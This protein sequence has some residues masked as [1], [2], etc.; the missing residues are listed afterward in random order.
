ML[1]RYYQ[2]LSEVIKWF[3]VENATSLGFSLNEIMF[4]RKVNKKR[5]NCFL[6]ES[7]TS[8]YCLQ[9]NVFTTQNQLMEKFLCPIS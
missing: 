5:Q 4:G 2:F 3:N 9:S 1:S 8:S 7:S 6:K